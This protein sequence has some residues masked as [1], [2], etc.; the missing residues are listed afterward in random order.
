MSY[1]KRVFEKINDNRYFSIALLP[2]SIYQTIKSYNRSKKEYKFLVET[3][4]SNDDFM[5]AL[6]TLGF[7]PVE[8]KLFFESVMPFDKSLSNEEIHKIASTSVISLIMNYV[9]NESLLG[10]VNV[11]CMLKDTENVKI[12]L[13]PATYKLYLNDYLDSVI[14]FCIYFGIS[15]LGILLYFLLK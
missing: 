10:V 4:N 1:F 5:K 14:S 3:I 12:I 6:G 8:N 2:L 9:K 11:D 13:R 15:I 7:Y